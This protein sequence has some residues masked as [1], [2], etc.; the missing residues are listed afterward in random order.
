MKT[1]E[2]TTRR[3]TGTFHFGGEILATNYHELI[4]T[5]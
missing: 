4:N 5:N 3:E 2:T 1:F